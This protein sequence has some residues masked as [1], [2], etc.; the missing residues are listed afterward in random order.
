LGIREPVR[1]ST[2]IS[3]VAEGSETPAQILLRQADVAMYH[4]KRP[5]SGSV[6]IYR[7]SLESRSGT[8]F[9]N[10]INEAVYR[11]IEQHEGLAMHYQPVRR[12]DDGTI[13]YYEA[14]MR[15]RHGDRLVYPDEILPLVESRHLER[16]LDQAVIDQ[17][18]KDFYAGMIPVGT[19]VAI[20]LSA[21]SI[22]DEN[23]LARLDPFRPFMSEHKLVLE[24]T[25]TTLITQM[26]LASG[27]LMQLR[28]Q[29][30]TI[31]LDDF[32][33]GYSSLSYLTSMPVDLVKFDITLVKA[34]HDEA[35][36][37]LVEHLLEFITSV[38]RVSVAEGVEDEAIMRQVRTLGFE[39]VQG[40]LHGR[41]TPLGP[42]PR[43]GNGNAA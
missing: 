38:G 20:N 37:R 8:I 40:F 34:L 26:E 25:E 41:P 15:I 2:G 35:H 12:V 9:S 16:E 32:G 31:A 18:L 30:F 11:V 4:S 3:P 17:L 39:Y 10:S 36:R 7:E 33:S 6:C 23:I 28:N 43:L 22:I 29:G 42:I 21:A 1:L 13:A 24:V 19:G 27:H 5:A 14:L